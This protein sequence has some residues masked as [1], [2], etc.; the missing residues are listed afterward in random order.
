MHNTPSIDLKSSFFTYFGDIPNHDD[1]NEKEED[2][3][4]PHVKLAR[5]LLSMF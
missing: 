1:D 4:L 2:L 5:L 3:V